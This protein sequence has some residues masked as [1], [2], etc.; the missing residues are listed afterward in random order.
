[1]P[2]LCFDPPPRLEFSHPSNIH[3]LREAVPYS[4][5]CANTLRIPVLPEYEMFKERMNL[6][7]DIGD[8]F[9]EH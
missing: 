6:A 2:P 3:D 5:A 9:T 1:M 4:N 7:L 8:I